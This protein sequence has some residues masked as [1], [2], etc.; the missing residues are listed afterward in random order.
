MH[1][2]VF[3][4]IPL[5]FA[6]ALGAAVNE[7]SSITNTKTACVTRT[8]T[9]SLKSVPTSSSTS[10]QVL[11]PNVITKT[12]R[13]TVKVTPKA[14]TITVTKVD[15]KK[16][17]TTLLTITKPLTTTVIQT[18]TVTST[19]FQTATSIIS[20]EVSSSTTV[21]STIPT[22]SGFLNIVD[23]APLVLQPTKREV[24]PLLQRGN[25]EGCTGVWFP[26][27]VTCN[28]VLQIKAII[29]TTVQ[30]SPVTITVPAPLLL[31]TTTI[32]STKTETQLLA[33]ATSTVTQTSTITTTMV[34]VGTTTSVSTTT[35]TVVSSTTVT[36]YAACSTNNIISSYNGIPVDS[37]PI[38]QL[39]G[40]NQMAASTHTDL[41]NIRTLFGFW[42]SY[43][44]DK[45]E[46]LSYTWGE[47][48]FPEIVMD[49][50]SGTVTHI[51]ENLFDALQA[52]RNENAPRL[53]WA[54][55]VCIHQFNLNE[56]G[57]HVAQMGAVYR[58]ASSVTVWLGQED[59]TEGIQVLRKLSED[60]ETI[61][62]AL[63][64]ND[65]GK[66][67][68]DMLHL[69]ESDSPLCKLFSGPWVER[70]WIVQE[71]VLAREVCIFV[72]NDSEE[73]ERLSIVITLIQELFS[74]IGKRRID[75]G[76]IVFYHT[77]DL[78]I[79]RDHYRQVILSNSCVSQ[80]VAGIKARDIVNLGKYRQC[81]NPRGRIFAMLGLF[82]Q[83]MAIVPDYNAILNEIIQDFTVKSRLPVQALVSDAQH[84]PIYG[85]SIDVVMSVLDVEHFDSF[86]S[87][88]PSA[89][90]FTAWLTQ[91]HPD[92]TALWLE[93]L[94][95]DARFSVDADTGGMRSN[96]PGPSPYKQ[97]YMGCRHRTM[98][99]G[100]EVAIFDSGHTPFMLRKVTDNQT[101][102]PDYQLVGDCC[103][104]GW[105]SGT[106]FGHEIEDEVC[107]LNAHLESD[108]E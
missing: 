66:A 74:K 98:D 13:T 21:T 61:I 80:T 60:K 38:F 91:F 85:T 64:F 26:A 39:S 71:F 69:T 96:L 5:L 4:T 67:M 79:F 58:N 103:L 29:T 59:A 33:K 89:S 54:D 32:T 100:D 28:T 14:K 17:T 11:P 53:L 7:G 62:S 73:L 40:P 102:H 86:S 27:S 76:N 52:L 94:K 65:G 56:K 88:A 95:Y 44:G 10:T 41:Y 63:D 43:L 2:K 106:Y 81:G 34:E 107:E 24:S 92:F 49:V 108:N 55:A 101:E 31:S 93:R 50:A 47:P 19:N 18:N 97:G 42:N 82:N 77:Y 23:S 9:K 46:A 57:H 25:K 8:G 37:V 87:S 90:H 70:L 105:M 104:R 36:S 16:V 51:T 75:Q 84:L 83:S 72:G 15:V 6:S 78:L 35:S 22:S 48:V 68:F 30:G 1:S 3:F 45:Y 99:P 20:T 12:S